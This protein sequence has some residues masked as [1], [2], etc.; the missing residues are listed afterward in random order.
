[1]QFV[2]KP[3]RKWKLLLTLVKRKKIKQE[4]LLTF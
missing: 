1:M 3:L 2:Q 4:N